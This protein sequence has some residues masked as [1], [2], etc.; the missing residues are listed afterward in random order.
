M[1]IYHVRQSTRGSCQQGSLGSRDG[2]GRM[3]GKGNSQ[4]KEGEVQ[5][6]LIFRDLASKA[7]IQGQ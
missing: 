6:L 2:T 3:K 7:K 4:M 1:S 5:K